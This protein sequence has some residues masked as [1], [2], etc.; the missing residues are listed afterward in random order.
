MAKRS[1]FGSRFGTIAVVGGS[2][3]GLG[4]IW[5]FPYIAGENG[6]G[7][8]L[9]VYV[10]VSFLVSV[11]IMLSE[12]TIGRASRRNSMRA[13]RKLSKIRSWRLTGYLGIVTAFTILSFYS[14]IAGWGLEFIKQ[15]LT[16]E[17]MSLAPE[18]IKEN[19]DG[20]V[21]TGWKPFLWT[22]GF[23]AF[24]AA[25]VAFGIEKGIERFNK[26]AMPLMFL[27]LVVMCVNAVTLPGFRQGM[28][29]LLKPDFSG[30]GLGTVLQAI[31]QSFFSL[32]LG[33]GIMVT[34][35][36]YIK[37]KQNMFRL[38]STVVMADMAIA[39]LSGI[40]IFPAVFS[41]GISPT[42]GPELVFLTLPNI[43]AQMTG[44]QI[45]ALLFFILLLAAAI[46]SS[47]SLLE[48]VVAYVLEEF[49]LRRRTATVITAAAVL[50]V[51]TLCLVSQMP[52]SGLSIAGRNIF[53]FLDEVT[54][55]YSIPLGGL[56]IVIFA[57]WV[58]N[59]S[60]FKRELTNDGLYGKA[61]YR[62]VR[63]MVKYV[64]PVVLAVLFL[65][66]AGLIKA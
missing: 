46:T 5:R 23:V 7:A 9:M 31:G 53:D 48:V 42:A 65:N 30:A 62:P 14:V 17:F 44:G 4:N 66:Q 11:P 12:F 34:Y 38:S 6:G 45:L 15:S 57:G 51:A 27:I 49:R 8:F 47:M 41:F 55:T 37:K 36:S 33:M 26:T 43:F 60:L 1:T 50:C 29:F 32:S 63:M 61:V 40:A 64:I 59:E 10:L 58:M 13:F 20:F 39:V 2:V 28:S 25:I 52:G 3:I 16:G 21:A 22:F 54:S 56:L 35:G 19:F 24:T 18:Q